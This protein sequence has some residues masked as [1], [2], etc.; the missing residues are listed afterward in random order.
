MSGPFFDEAGYEIPRSS[1]L[2]ELGE[3]DAPV[4]PKDTSPIDPDTPLGRAIRA[5]EEIRRR[6]R[7]AS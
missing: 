7:E 1:M 5:A 3:P 2:I 6:Q 4:T